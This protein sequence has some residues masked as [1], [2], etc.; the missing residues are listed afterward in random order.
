M[1]FLITGA[2]GFIGYHLSLALLKAK[3]TVVGLDNLN[4]YY[5]VNLKLARLKQLEAEPHFVFVKEDLANR[6]AIATLFAREGFDVVV[7]L[8]AQAGVRYSLQNPFAYID[9]NLVGFCSILEGCRH[10]KVKHLIY[11]SSSSVYGANEKQPF[12]ETDPVNHPLALYAATKKA[13]EL[14]AHAYAN[15][16]QL[17]C[18]G[19]RF[20]TVYG[21]WGRPD[22]ALFKFTQNILAG[23]PIDV[24]NNGNMIRDFTYV[25]DIIRAIL[26]II[27]RGPAEPNPEWNGRTPDPS[28]SYAPYEIYNIGNSCPTPLMVFIEAIEKALGKK[29]LLNLLPMQEGDVPST[30]ADTHH[31]EKTFDF[32]PNTAIQEGIKQ[33]TDWY[34]SYY[35]HHES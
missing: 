23:K 9:S 5:D 32:K 7:N 13:N 26:K 34:V 28:S 33:F 4:D 11:A 22:M 14:M 15:L 10:Q 8:A 29:A 24:Y 12:Q 2:A 21:P 20:F 35:S 17:P 30:H 27:E 1:K 31:L 16:Y 6:E 25:D 18:T 19:L 3:Q